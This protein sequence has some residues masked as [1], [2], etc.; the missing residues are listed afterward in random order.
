MKLYAPLYYKKF[1]CIADRCRHSCCVGW[2]I[3]IDSESMEKYASCSTE[4]GKIIANSIENNAEPHF[5][6]GKDERCPHLNC[7]GLCNIILELGEDYLCHIC[8]EHP[9]FYNDTPRGREVGLGMAC[10]EACRIIL[11]SDDYNKFVEIDDI[12]G[13]NCDSDF[14]SLSLRDNLYGI[15]CDNLLSYDKKL[16][17]IYAWCRVSPC[18]IPDEEARQIIDNL[19]YLDIKHKEL[20]MAYSSD[21]KIPKEFEKP[22]E[23]ALAYFV[24][25]HCTE[26]WDEDE[27]RAS[28]GFCLFCE[29]L[30][31]SIAK[32]NG[33]LCECAR[34]LS[35]E[36]EYSEENTEMIK[37]IFL[38]CCQSM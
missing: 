4:Y 18:L 29:R 36:I 6:L 1:E 30:L 33:D 27:F 31:A 17:A 9:R 23:R 10:E 25:R 24:Y 20:F 15:L 38:R 32:E 2:E 22:L 34:I 14:D 37:D 7:K 3:D 35:E 28:L 11:G 26:V 13:E 5:K 21:T 16:S 12:A 8:R 19:E